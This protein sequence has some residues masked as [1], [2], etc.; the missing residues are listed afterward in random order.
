MSDRQ[1]AVPATRSLSARGVLIWALPTAFTLSWLAYVTW[2]GQWDRVVGHW[3]TGLTMI[4]GSFVAGSTPQGGGAVAFPVF[5]KVLE[6]P[7]AVARTFSVSIQATGMVMASLSIL[8][9]GRRIDKRALG[10]GVLGGSIGFMIGL[11]VLS[12]P[13][14]IWWESRISAPYVK[15]S[16]TIAIAAMAYIVY[17]CFVTGASGSEAVDDWTRTSASTLVLFA[18]VGGIASALTGSGVDV[19]LFL[20]VVLVAGLHPRVGIPTSIITMAVVSTLGLVVLGI[21]DGQLAIDLDAS[22]D[23]VAVGG[24]E[25]DGLD[26]TRFDLFG[27]WLG[28][29]PLV[30]WGA[31]LGSWVAS[32]LNERA[33]ITFVAGM[34]LLEVATTI[35]FL[36]ALHDDVR[37]V[38]FGVVGLLGALGAVR[39]LARHRHQIMGTT[40]VERDRVEVS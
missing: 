2:S 30:V 21:V 4:F 1:I 17:L 24:T 19:M 20:F 38:V 32:I 35:I 27:I 25:V 16:F 3:R 33:L 18:V 10:L 29:A 5:T 22:G 26:P 13:G 23:V 9:A 8:L 31:P 40:A 37:L 28:A 15:V 12:D 6:I 7:A 34:A 36:D 11:F 39:I 14:T